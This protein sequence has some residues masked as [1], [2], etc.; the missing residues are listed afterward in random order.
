[1]VETSSCSGGKAP[2]TTDSIRSLLCESCWAGPFAFDAFRRLVN[3]EH[4]HY[5]TSWTR[6]Q[7]GADSG[8]GFCKILVVD[9]DDAQE[10]V[11]FSLSF[12]ALP[13]YGVLPGV[14]GSAITSPTPPGLQ[15]L[16]YE[17]VGSDMDMEFCNNMWF[18]RTSSDDP[19]ASEIVARDPILEV[20]S[21]H[22][23]ALALEQVQECIR[24]HKDCPK[25]TAN[26]PLPT[27]VIDCKDPAHP[28]LF[29]SGGTAG[30]YA[31][32]SYVWGEDQTKKTTQANLATYTRGIDLALIPQTIRDAIG[33]TQR[34]GLRYLWV[35]S[36]CIIQD[37]RDDKA[38]ELQN[39]RRIFRHAHITIIAASA[40]SASSGFLQKREPAL[41][42]AEVQTPRLPY[43]CADGR[44]GTMTAEPDFLSVD[45]RRDPVNARAWCLEE[46]VLSPRKLV[47]GSDTLQYH[48]Q[49]TVNCIGNAIA[50]PRTAERLHNVT[51]LSDSDIAA[52]VSQ[53]T[54]GAWAG[55]Q[56][57][58][59]D[60]LSN[61]TIRAV[62]KPK[63]KLTALA[64]VAEQVHRVWSQPSNP[65]MAGSD[66]RFANRYIAGLWGQSLLQ[67][68]LWRR[69]T[70]DVSLAPRPSQYYLAPSWSWASVHGPV[71]L[72][73]AGYDSRLRPPQ[74]GGTKKLRS[75]KIVSCEVTLEDERLPYGRVKDGIL[76]LQAKLLPTSWEA[77]LVEPR[78]YMSREAN[79]K[80]HTMDA[81]R[82]KQEGSALECVGLVYMD[83]TDEVH[84][85][86]WAVPILWNL[87]PS[88]DLIYASGLFVTKAKDGVRFTRIG[89][90]LSPELVDDSDE[91][92]ARVEAWISWMETFSGDIGSLPVIEII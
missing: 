69:N 33:V 11:I 9:Q 17:I 73:D 85:Q 90:W 40:P 67:D 83:S 49:T 24:N 35:D 34:V 81:S 70:Y 92:L 44:L 48:C 37:S 66:S 4:V 65:L 10:E 20:D 75:A 32:L 51:F 64:A 27:R 53:W 76:R 55:F 28:R 12:H 91:S 39:L 5:R 72:L 25:S 36:F 18:V 88:W 82:E 80:L 59:S 56:S 77:N 16:N 2:S 6:V 22:C 79:Y 68:L 42:S 19:A 38:K 21:P 60:F 50:R 46:R 62:T 8:C 57:E 74:F 29:N 63:D 30:Q 7:Q 84:G 3:R 87:G 14:S 31:A 58:W 41:P 61:Y 54:K 52:H 78:L 47:Y 89:L 43:W 86:V 13:A 23:Y 1:M 15:C 26:G 45:R 71:L